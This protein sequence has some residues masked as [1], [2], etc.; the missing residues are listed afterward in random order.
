MEEFVRV[1]M[2]QANAMDLTRFQ[3]DYDLT[4]AAFF[5][6]ADGT[7]YGRFGSRSSQDAMENMSIPGFRLALK[8]A[9][10]LHDGYPANRDALAGKQPVTPR[11]TRPEQY[12]SLAS[13]AEHLDYDG[14]VV[15]SCMHCHQIN[16]AE[17]M[18]YREA[19]QPVPD[20][21][22]FPWP[23]PRIIGL[24]FDRL[25]QATV[26]AVAPHSLAAEAGL[27]A[28]DVVET[29]NDQPIVSVADVQWILHHA[30][31]G[32]ELRLRALRD[33]APLDVAVTLPAGWRKNTDI[34]WRVSSWDVR[35][36]GTGGLV[37]RPLTDEQRAA[38]ELDVAAL[39]LRVDG[40]SG[41]P[42]SYA[43]KAGFQ[44]EDIIVAFD[45]Q[46]HSMTRSQ[47]LA[48]TMQQTTAGQILPV[49]V[50]RGGVLVDLKLPTQ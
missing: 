48:Y 4:F 36:M 26:S 23:A 42:H 10:D 35:R 50:L 44:K 19:K 38:A 1:R 40:M 18:L 32:D 22:M 49:T 15:K 41:G 43:K 2:V 45:G 3:F 28:G 20:K 34:A 7:I 31:D 46:T 47:L 5:I 13:Y 12:P 24:V 39:G 14:E 30:E 29:I 16:E 8:A 17:R 21:V 37:L 11:Y 27:Q 6:N 25:E 33:R 9:L